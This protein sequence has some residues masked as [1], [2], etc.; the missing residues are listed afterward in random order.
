MKQEV[1]SL[2]PVVHEL[3]CLGTLGIERNFFHICDYRSWMITE[4]VGSMGSSTGVDKGSPFDST[5]R[6]PIWKHMVHLYFTCRFT[7]CSYG[8]LRKTIKQDH[9]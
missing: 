6:W 7:Y 8:L 3:L 1:L 9:L 4:H 5:R 2:K